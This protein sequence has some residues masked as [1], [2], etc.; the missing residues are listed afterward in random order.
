MWSLRTRCRRQALVL[1]ASKYTRASSRIFNDVL[2]TNKKPA[3]I[4]RASLTYELLTL[5]LTY[6][7]AE[8]ELAAVGRANT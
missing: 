4:A 7:F 2:R 6:F 3:Q 1:P 8:V 5:L